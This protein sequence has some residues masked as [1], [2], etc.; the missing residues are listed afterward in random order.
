MPSKPVRTLATETKDRRGR[1][2]AEPLASGA[3]HTNHFP[4]SEAVWSEAT[5]LK[6]R[7]RGLL[8]G[9]QK[10]PG[11]IQP[12]PPAIVFAA[13]RRCRNQRFFHAV[14][15]EDHLQLRPQADQRANQHGGVAF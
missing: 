15:A 13:V 1:P 3:E 10:D 5:K 6:W 7:Y 14:L 8:F 9:N 2:R 12:Y 4:E 11:K